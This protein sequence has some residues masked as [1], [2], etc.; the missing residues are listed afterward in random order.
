MG[1]EC[2]IELRLFMTLCLNYSQYPARLCIYRHCLS[3]TT[4]M[5]HTRLVVVH[6]SFHNLAIIKLGTIFAWKLIRSR[7]ICGAC[8]RDEILSGSC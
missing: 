1:T 7:R 4:D 2:S 3:Q 5:T 8:G 6:F